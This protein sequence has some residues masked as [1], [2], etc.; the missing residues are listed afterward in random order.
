ML[1]EGFSVFVEELGVG[2]FQ[3]PCELR[4]VGL[5]GVDLIAFRVD[6]EE[7]V[8]IGWRLELLRDLRGKTSG[9]NGVR[10]DQQCDGCNEA[11]RL[12]HGRLPVERNSFG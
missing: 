9:K 7:Q 11:N 2:G 1:A 4:G 3:R 10:G 8:L 6:L 5:A 12:A